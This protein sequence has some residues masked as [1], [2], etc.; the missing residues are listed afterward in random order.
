LLPASVPTGF[1]IT[2]TGAHDISVQS[3][4]GLLVCLYESSNNQGTPFPSTTTKKEKQ[5]EKQNTP[6]KP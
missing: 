3:R 2:K 6:L 1:A 5:K 4:N